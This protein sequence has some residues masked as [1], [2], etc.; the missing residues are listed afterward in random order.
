MA[1]SAT[2]FGSRFEKEAR[3]AGPTEGDDQSIVDLFLEQLNKIKYCKTD[4][5]FHTKNS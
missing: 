2:K 3:E 4:N 1:P 5:C